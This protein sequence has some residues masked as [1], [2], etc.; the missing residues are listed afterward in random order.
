MCIFA[1][2][3][4]N[5]GTVSSAL[6]KKL[7]GD[8]LRGNTEILREAVTLSSYAVESEEAKNVRAGAADQADDDPH[9]GILR[10]SGSDE[11]CESC[12]ICQVV[13]R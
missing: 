7:A 13:P 11:R 5:K 6:G 9:D 4:A 3:G 8:V 10:T 1:Q 2:L 12:A